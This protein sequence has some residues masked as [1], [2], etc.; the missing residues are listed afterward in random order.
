M[1]H[2][3]LVK[4]LDADLLRLLLL[5]YYY[6]QYLYKLD[7]QYCNLYVLYVDL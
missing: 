6:Y 7:N 3:P 4:N 5:Y 1:A 2:G